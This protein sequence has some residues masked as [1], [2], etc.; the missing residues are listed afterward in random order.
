MEHYSI[1]TPCKHYIC[2]ECFYKSI[3]KD[4]TFK[5]G[6]CRKNYGNIGSKNPCELSEYELNDLVT[7][8]D[9]SDEY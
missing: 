3:N 4:K 8:E 1:K 5:C 2:S 7:S 6:V 9:D